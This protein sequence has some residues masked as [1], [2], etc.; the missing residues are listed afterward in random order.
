[1]SLLSVISVDTQ[2]AAKFCPLSVS[3]F[4]F[5]FSFF[6]KSSGQLDAVVVVFVCRV[7]R[8][9]TRVVTRR[10]RI[11][12]RL[13]GSPPRLVPV[14]PR[15]GAA[16][17]AATQAGDERRGSGQRIR[18]A[19]VLVSFPTPAP[20]GSAKGAPAPLTTLT[21]QF[22]PLVHLRLDRMFRLLLC[23]DGVFTSS[24]LSPDDSYLLCV[25]M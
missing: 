15:R 6:L 20:N 8:S 7:L 24:S 23:N 19:L 16:P 17:P 2:V 21:G 10:V 22:S 25:L 14:T 13:F 1:M 4:C 18:C 9:Y 12:K 3:V 11:I 5:V